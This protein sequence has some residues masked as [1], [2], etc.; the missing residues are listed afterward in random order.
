MA[1]LWGQT[2]GRIRDEFTEAKFPGASGIRSQQPALKSP[3]TDLYSEGSSTAVPEAQTC[4]YII[5]QG[6][7]HAIPHRLEPG[8]RDLVRNT[9]GLH[10]TQKSVYKKLA[11]LTPENMAALEAVLD[12]GGSGA[13]TR[14]LVELSVLHKSPFH[15]GGNQEPAVM[16]IVEDVNTQRPWREDRKNLLESDNDGVGPTSTYPKETFHGGR[17]HSVHKEVGS[18]SHSDVYSDDTY[19]AARPQHRG[20]QNVS[21][22]MMNSEDYREALTTYRVWVI[23]QHSGLKQTQPETQSWVECT[24]VEDFCSR[25]DIM[26]RLRVMDSKQSSAN[27]KKLSL[28][29]DQQTQIDRLHERVAHREGSGEYQWNLR[30]LDLIRSRSNIFQLIPTITA[31]FVYLA[32]T[33]RGHVDLRRLFEKEMTGDDE[34]KEYVSH[35]ARTFPPNQ[36]APNFDNYDRGNS[37]P[38]YQP[39]IP[40]YDYRWAPPATQPRPPLPPRPPYNPHGPPDGIPQSNAGPSGSVPPPPI[41]R[42]QPRPKPHSFADELSD[43]SSGWSMSSSYLSR[44]GATMDYPKK[45]KTRIPMRLVSK[46]ALI[47]LG[48]PF[49]EEASC[50]AYYQELLRV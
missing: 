24:V 42:P 23:Q 19:F 9:L 50:Y 32:R 2:R 48:Y 38:N 11:S 47:D 18:L 26:Q 35:G 5:K 4:V 33:P 17:Q 41:H 27:M 3:S 6:R 36:Y 30:Q 39:H 46:R 20:I 37:L 31:I 34:Y 7:S 12:N 28:R 15:I 40:D 45:G 43:E 21:S 8:L 44:G 13:Q 25:E 22:E 14:K 29:P 10:Q 1:E 49:V 16:A